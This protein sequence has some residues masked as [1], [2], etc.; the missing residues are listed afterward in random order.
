MLKNVVGSTT[1]VW[2]VQGHRRRTVVMVGVLAAVVAVLLAFGVSERSAS[3]QSEPETVGAVTG[4]TATAEGQVDGTARLTWNAAENAQVYFV[5]YLKEDDFTTG[6]YGDIQMR[7]FNGTEGTIDG[8]AGGTTYRFYATGMRWN[9]SNFGAVWGGWSAPATATPLAGTVASTV[10]SAQ[11]EPE[12]VGAVTGLAATTEGQA[13]GTVRLTWNVAENAQVY[14]VLYLKE[15]DFTAGNYGDIRMRAFNGTEGRIGELAGG[16]AYRFYATGMRWN[17]SN[18]GAVWGGWSAPATATPTAEPTVPLSDLEHWA[19]LETN[20]AAEASRIKALPWVA[21]GVVES[22]REAAELLIAAALRHPDVFDTLMQKS[23]V[24]DSITEHE[25]TAIWGIRWTA[26]EDTALADRVLTKSWVQD[27]IT[28]DEA[29]VIKN[30]YWIIR[31]EDESLE[32]DVIQAV[33]E[34]LGMPFLDTVESPDA[35][36]VRSLE[37]FEDAGSAEFLELMMHPTISDGIDDEEAK[38]LVVLGE[39]KQY[40]PQSVPVLL[41]GTSVFKEERI[42]NLPHSGEVLLAIIR[43]H[44]HINPNMD[45]LEHAVRHHEGFMGEPLPTNYVAWYFVDYTPSGWNAGTH[46]ASNQSRDPR[47]R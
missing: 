45:Y 26:R 31:A 21:D 13:D 36:T 17:F 41:D 43:F 19:W 7:A 1:L 47:H 12:T 15:D 18:F 38:I 32:Q 10:P 8:L 40:K 42:I 16:T 34:I 3:A 20:K 24:Q 30:L 2:L 35:S 14:F 6:N 39:T 44:D 46:I 5:L 4:L 9:F 11:S 33:I 22:E 27:G 37:R 28:R 29:V 25:T 23:W